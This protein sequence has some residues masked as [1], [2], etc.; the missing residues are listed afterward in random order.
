M[1][2]R[3]RRKPSWTGVRHDYRQQHRGWGH[4]IGFKPEGKT[5][6][7]HMWSPR[8][9]N[10]GDRI[11]VGA[12]EDLLV[13]EAKGQRDPRDMYFF[14]AVPTPAGDEPPAIHPNSGDWL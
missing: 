11:N 9:V 6:R 13:T 1:G 12:S 5:Y 4:D 8:R 10:V 7:G 3:L 2:L 14:A